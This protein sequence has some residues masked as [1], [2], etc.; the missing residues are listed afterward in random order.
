MG[1]V[2]RAWG[3][4]VRG[5]EREVNEKKR[6]RETL[7]KMGSMGMNEGLEREVGLKM[8]MRCGERKMV[9]GMRL[10]GYEVGDE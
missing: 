2:M 5:E 8:G 9:M 10:V 1:W 4:R 3:F 6:V 7:K